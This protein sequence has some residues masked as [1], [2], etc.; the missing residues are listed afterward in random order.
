[1]F[2]EEHTKDNNKDTRH[3]IMQLSY[4]D[5]PIKLATRVLVE[6]E[7]EKGTW[8]ASDAIVATID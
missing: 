5:A 8:Y 1:M 4:S 3:V 2:I 6:T 7:I